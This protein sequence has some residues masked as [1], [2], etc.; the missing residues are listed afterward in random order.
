VKGRLQH[1]AMFFTA[2]RCLCLEKKARAPFWQRSNHDFFRVVEAHFVA[3]AIINWVVRVE[4]RFAMEAAFSS[5]PSFFERGCAAN[6]K[7]WRARGRPKREKLEKVPKPDK[8]LAEHAVDFDPLIYSPGL[9]LA[10]NICP[11][12]ALRWPRDPWCR[13]VSRVYYISAAPKNCFVADL[14]ARALHIAELYPAR[15]ATRRTARPCVYV[16]A[17]YY[18]SL[19]LPSFIASRAAGNIRCRQMP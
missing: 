12:K 13:T 3:A 4:A 19:F 1:T 5:V 11:W 17:P 2:T 6:R 14:N 10:L 16:R 7:R 18:P 9:E 8:A 15:S